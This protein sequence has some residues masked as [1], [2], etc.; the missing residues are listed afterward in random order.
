MQGPVVVP[1]RVAVRPILLGMNN[2]HSTRLE[3]ALAPFPEGCS[4]Y[5]LWKVL[6]DYYGVLKKDYL[7]KFDRRNLVN[8]KQWSMEKA[9]KA[10]SL[11]L[12]HAAGRTI[13][14]LGDDVR[15]AL[16]VEKLEPGVRLWCG[17]TSFY[18]LPHPS[19]RCHWYNDE[20]NRRLAADLLKD[21]YDVSI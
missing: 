9:K 17:G 4:G 2:P 11:F 13:V 6:Y 12:E 3:L 20:S 18:Q 10:A 16:G 5:R 8:E 19:G 21:L 7:T 14:L 1:V 15:R